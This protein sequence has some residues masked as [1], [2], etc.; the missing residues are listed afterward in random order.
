M[1]ALTKRFKD[2]TAITVSVVAGLTGAAVLGTGISRLSGPTQSFASVAKPLTN[3]YCGQNN[4]VCSNLQLK[5]FM[6]GDTASPFALAIKKTAADTG[7]VVPDADIQKVIM[8]MRDSGQLDS[9]SPTPVLGKSATLTVIKGPQPMVETLDGA[10]IGGTAAH[11]VYALIAN[12]TKC[13]IYEMISGVGAGPVVQLRPTDVRLIPVG[14]HGA[15]NPA[16]YNDAQA[17]S[18][19]M[20]NAMDMGRV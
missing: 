10:F 19:K 18:K 16:C 4:M 13:D 7:T 15:M 2:N 1:I 8:M 6:D 17:I 5:Q 3:G 12:G 11:G 14:S 20:A 9:A